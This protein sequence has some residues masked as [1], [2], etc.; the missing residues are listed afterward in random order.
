MD[1]VN[2]LFFGQRDNARNVE[3]SFYGTF[4]GANLISLIR[5]K[6]V[7]GEAVFLRIDRHGAQAQLIGR[8]KDANG[9]FAAVGRQQFPN[10]LCFLHQAPGLSQNSILSRS[11]RASQEQFFRYSESK[12]FMSRVVARARS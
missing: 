4:A 6:A 3:I 9:D 12:A 1:R 11:R 10:G 5:L 7:Q 2:F 8:T